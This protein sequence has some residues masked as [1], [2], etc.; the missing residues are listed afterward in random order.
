MGSA[1]SATAESLHLE[2]IAAAVIGGT[3]MKG[4]EGSLI[5][6]I[7]GAMLISMIRNGLNLVGLSYFYQ[8]VVTGSIILIASILDSLKHRIS[9]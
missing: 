1:R 4:G 9:N 6:T 8:L 5:G 3:N 7:V 2:C